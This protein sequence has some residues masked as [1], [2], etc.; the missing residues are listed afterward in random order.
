MTIVPLGLNRVSVPLQVNRA[1][2]GLRNSQSQVASLEQ[3][4]LTQHQFQYGSDSPYNASATLSVQSQIERK[5]QNS[6][7][8]KS[9]LTFLTATDSTLARFSPLT[10]DARAMGLEALNTTTSATQRN[11]LA[12]TIKQSVQQV[13][14]FSNYSFQG[15][16]LFAG[17][18]TANIP[19]KW[20]DD[21]YTIQYTGSL[22]D[23]QSW[24][25]SDLLS[26]SNMNG[27]DVFGAISKP[28][29]GKTDLNP[30]VSEMTLLQDLNGGKGVEKGAIRLT[31]T[32]EDR[33]ATYDVDL[34]QCVTLAD[35]MR[36]LENYKNPS[37]S[38]QTSLTR[39][40]LS[41]VLSPDTPGSVTISNIEKGQ[42]AGQLGI[43]LN[44]P[45]TRE[46]PLV[47]RDIN[48]ILTNTTELSQILGAKA[49]LTLRFAGPNND[50][51]VQARNNG[52]AVINKET[53]EIDW[54]LNG[55]NFNILS[56]TSITPS[57]EVVEYDS[58][59]KTVQVRIH[60]DNTNANYI[61]NAINKAS[62]AGTIPP[63]QAS[64]S[65]ID[66]QR[67]E[68]AGT[69]IVSL[70]PGMLL[71]EGAAIGGFGV[72]FDATGIELINN[73]KTQLISFEQCRTIGDMLAELNDPIYGLYSTIN[74][75]GNG[76]DIRSRVS[77]ADFCIGEN[78]GITA[79]Q[80]GVRTT[81]LNT[82]LQ[83]LDYGRGVSDYTGP[84]TAAT[85]RYSNVTPNSNLVL[86]ARNEGEEWN[87]YTVNFVPTN[88]PLGRVVVSMDDNAK[89]ITI[90]INPGVTTACDIVAAFESQ[91]GPKQFFNLELDS[92][93]G[94][95][96]GTGV[97]FDGFTKTSGGENGGI[98]F[99]IT[100]NDGTLLSVDI[101]GAETIGDVLRIINENAKNQDGLLVAKLS[102]NGNGIELVDSSFGNFVTRVDR[103]LLSTT[104]I[105]LGLVNLGEEYRT[106]TTAGTAAN[107]IANSDVLNGAIL[108]SG[109]QV[110]T[111]ANDVNVQFVAALGD[112]P[113][114]FWNAETKT[115]QFAVTPETTAN[116]VIALFQNQA[117]ESVRNMFV[118]QNGLNPN[119]LPSDGT[120]LIEL[121]TTTLNG[122]NNA[123][124]KGK[125]PNPQETDS[126]FNALIRLQVAMEKNDTREIDRAMF[127]L[128][129]SVGILND[130]RA[131]IGVMQ[132]SLDNIQ[133]RLAEENIQQ[134][135]T[136][137]TVF[138]IDYADVSLNYYA[139]ML[140]YQAALQISSSI[141]QMSLLNYI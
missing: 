56:D 123:E 85:A 111:Y 41:I 139:Q 131:T 68:L 90:A 4:L 58:E 34:S 14:N 102:K 129:N 96:N 93:G 2:S 65:E 47:G 50:I 84:G 26:Q 127:L 121:G 7:N 25:D 132:N 22:V 79:S 54:P 20:G 15:R 112:R 64:L 104:A 48:P 124:L 133:I 71:Q 44:V 78:G 94:P 109:K 125:D 29:R 18:D 92:T 12:Q 130:S 119:G 105:E 38:L 62:D 3:Q 89:E 36:T 116:D 73:N 19:F 115:M 97:V 28:V 5:L 52:D 60:P 67:T 21:S 16:Y 37:F 27:G 13:F 117:S 128:D 106:K 126:L 53:G 120:G 39:D 95:N 134:E 35:V 42:V 100:R 11:A 138:R 63:F 87:N 17:A 1:Y 23:L 86:T 31:Y 114:F 70:L 81:D 8:L 110:G 77:G 9:S 101:H 107:G 75:A 91:P 40:G 49:R 45:V 74:A 140:S 136:L 61:T 69:G 122:G 32:Y 10:D 88:D 51:V 137:N 57:E 76:I 80:L 103:T 33:S 46:K 24:S 83:E 72:D 99:T 118:L 59:T 66:Q 113:E 82:K 43:P 55:V 108:V 6:S 135:E 30:S 141:L 98:D